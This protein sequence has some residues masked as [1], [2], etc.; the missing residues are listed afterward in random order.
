[1]SGSVSSA[2][3][4]SRSV[5]TTRPTGGRHKC[6][7]LAVTLV[8]ALPCGN[9]AGALPVQIQ[10]SSASTAV[11]FKIARDLSLSFDHHLGAAEAQRRVAARLER[12]RAEFANKVGSSTVTW[13]G[14]NALVEVSAF[15]QNANGRVYVT[16]TN[17]R[18]QVHLP[19]LLA[20]LGGKIESFLTKLSV[21]TLQGDPPAK[22]HTS[23][24]KS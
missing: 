7:V 22:P 18:I 19:L 9:A 8:G 1:M 10:H 6:L 17:V 2:I 14:N 20:P 16:D 24:H 11:G 3:I 4:S 12:L 13:T 23:A 15:G 5:P 21:E